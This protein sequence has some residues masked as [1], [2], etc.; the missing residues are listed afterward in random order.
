MS[1]P[2]RP[3]AHYLASQPGLLAPRRRALRPLR[4]WMAQLACG[5]AYSLKP[6][7]W[8]VLLPL[9]LRWVLSVFRRGPA[10]PESA[11]AIPW[12]KGFADVVR[13]T[14]TPAVLEGYRRGLYPFAHLGPLKWWAPPHRMVLFLDE[15]RI[16]KSLRRALRRG[17]FTVTFDRAFE[18][19]IAGCAAPRRGR[20]PLTWITSRI[21]DIFCRLHR[22]GHAHSV[23]VWNTD[24]RLVGGLYGLAVGRVFFTESQFHVERD[25]SKAALTVLNRHLQHWGFA[26]NDGKHWTQHLAA[27]GFRVVPKEHL[28]A[29]L[30]TYATPVDEPRRWV[31]DAALDCAEWE[32][33]KALHLRGK[34]LAP[35]ALTTDRIDRIARF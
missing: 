17:R 31:V 19:V 28:E 22:E 26:F 20:P 15:Y 24:G 30:A 7:R 25:A 18:R 27:A 29:L 11:R 5:C 14:S 33:D 32:P 23:E 34:D 3:L 1:G 12:A 4:P 16:E 10:V 6:H 9:A 35:R 21:V 8:P 13:D 2:T